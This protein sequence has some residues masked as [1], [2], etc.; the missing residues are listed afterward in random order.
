[1]TTQTTQSTLP[2]HHSDPDTIKQRY[3]TERFFVEHC[4]FGFGVFANRDIAAGEIILSFGGPI[5]DFQETKRRGPRECMAIQI[6]PNRY[7][8][9]QPP[10]VLV[11]HSCN[12]NAGVWD[13]QHL[14]A[15]RPI[16]K[17]EQIS[18]DYSTTMQENS[19]EMECLC[20]TPD[21]R[22]IVKDFSTLPKKIQNR[23]LAKG[24]VMSFIAEKCAPAKKTRRP[25][26]A[27]R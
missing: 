21:C 5:I 9:T 8:D 12:P 18:F 27:S 4:A 16:A 1:M 13:D 17:G 3:S 24:M 14:V 10:G 7:F 15:M 25:V 20:G 26:C 23:Y 11:N 22:H 19:Y 2:F 6:G